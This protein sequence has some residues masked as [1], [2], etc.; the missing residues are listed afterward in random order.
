MLDDEQELSETNCFPETLSSFQEDDGNFPK[1]EQVE[2]KGVDSF[3]V[4]H[5]L[6]EAGLKIPY[7]WKTLLSSVSSGTKER[8]VS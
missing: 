8:R 1:K 5:V 6:S 3:K 2:E 7:I 4:N